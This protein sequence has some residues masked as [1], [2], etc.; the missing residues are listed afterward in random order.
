MPCGLLHYAVRLNLGVRPCFPHCCCKGSWPFHNLRSSAAVGASHA[1][2]SH[3]QLVLRQLDFGQARLSA[4]FD[5]MGRLRSGCGESF[6]PRASTAWLRSRQRHG[7]S[8]GARL[9]VL[10]GARVG[11][12]QDR[13]Q[14]W[15]RRPN[16]AFKPKPLR[17][18]VQA[19]GKACHLVRSTTRLGLT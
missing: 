16:N 19:A 2:E 10:F 7:Q 14:A 4:R 8:P 18:A 15:L 17:Y 9:G 3:R 11:L 5:L 1:Q 6:W 12:S 13:A